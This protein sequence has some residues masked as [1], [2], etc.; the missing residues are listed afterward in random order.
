MNASRFQLRFSN[1]A[2]NCAQDVRELSPYC[3]SVDYVREKVRDW[4]AGRGAA[5]TRGEANS[6]DASASLLA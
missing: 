6:D 5:I 4:L 1:P 2:G 3:H